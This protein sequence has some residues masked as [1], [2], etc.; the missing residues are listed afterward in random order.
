MRGFLI[1]D[2][3]E[4]QYKIEVTHS[5]INTLIPIIKKINDGY[6]LGTGEGYDLFKEIYPNDENEITSI[7][8]VYHI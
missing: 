5:Q 7:N 3:E 1:I 4:R 6:E 8:I 2:T